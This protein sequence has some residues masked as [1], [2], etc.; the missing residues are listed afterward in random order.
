[1][2]STI[3]LM[4]TVCLL[5]SCQSPSSSDQSAA[6]SAPKS[7]IIGVWEIQEAK[8]SNQDS[9][10]ISNPYRSVVIF[11]QGYYS[12]E[13]ARTNRPSLPQLAEGESIPEDVLRSTYNG[14][15][16]NSGTYELRG[17]SLYR[18]ARIAKHPNYMND[19]PET[20][21][22]CVVDGDRMVINGRTPSGYESVVTYR[23]LE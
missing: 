11:T 13:I 12:V 15:T 3:M 5:T 18:V 2:K 10:W 21:V 14:L 20:A 23:R 16:S 22:R 17:D 6:D 19:F 1:M 8:I 9:S 4:A 7:G